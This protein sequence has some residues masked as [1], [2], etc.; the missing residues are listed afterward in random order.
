MTTPRWKYAKDL[1][2]GDKIVLSIHGLR[3]DLEVLSTEFKRRGALEYYLLTGKTLSGV[4]MSTSCTKHEHI[5]LIRAL[6][7]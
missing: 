2:A 1:K 7:D 3:Q 4:E 6:R 5:R